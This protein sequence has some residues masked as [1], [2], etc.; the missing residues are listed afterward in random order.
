MRRRD[1]LLASRCPIA[2]TALL[3]AATGTAGLAQTAP[4]AADAADI[5]VTAQRRSERLVDVPA[6]VVAA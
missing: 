2:V 3:L 6:S 1:D 5:I 4:V